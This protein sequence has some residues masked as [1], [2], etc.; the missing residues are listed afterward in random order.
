MQCDTV[1]IH[2]LFIKKQ[3]KSKQVKKISYVLYIVLKLVKGSR[4]T[5]EKI[6]GKSRTELKLYM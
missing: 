6:S 1:R 2:L 3:F 5:S 4:I